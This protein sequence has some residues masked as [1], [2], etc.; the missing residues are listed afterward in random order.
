[1]DFII[2]DAA[3]REFDVEFLFDFFGWFGTILPYE[4]EHFL[5]MLTLPYF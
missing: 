2:N 5:A 4:V 3:M 1:M